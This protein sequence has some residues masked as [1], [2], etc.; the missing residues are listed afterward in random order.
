LYLKFG[1][2]RETI[3]YKRGVLSA[4][5]AKALVTAADSGAELV[6]LIA[7]DLATRPD[8]TVVDLVNFSCTSLVADQA[9]KP[10]ETSA[11][12]WE[13]EGIIHTAFRKLDFRKQI[14]VVIEVAKAVGEDDNME[15]AMQ[16]LLTFTEPPIGSKSERLFSIGVDLERPKLSKDQALVLLEA[17]KYFAAKELKK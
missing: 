1:T 14:D 12:L 9:G 3:M 7:R 2:N 5:S 6:K 10:S 15:A 16:N 8:C 11:E 4:L 17:T 13:W